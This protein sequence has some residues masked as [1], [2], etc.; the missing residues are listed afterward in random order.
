LDWRKLVEDYPRPKRFGALGNSKLGPIYQ[1]SGLSIHSCPGRTQECESVCYEAWSPKTFLGGERLL[2]KAAWYNYLAETDPNRLAKLLYHE[3]SVEGTDKI[4]IHVGGD[5]MNKKLIEVWI[6]LAL[7]FED[8]IFCAYTRSWREKK[9]LPMLTRLRDL[10]NVVLFAS[11]DSESGMPPKGWQIAPLETTPEEWL[12]DRKVID[13]PEQMG[14]KS[15]CNSCKLCYNPN[16][17]VDIRFYLHGTKGISFK[18]K[19]EKSNT[20]KLV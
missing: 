15:N 18:R 8:K 3:L 10:P 6:S 13:C 7:K 9:L 12:T 14:K 1:V 5:F 17:K 16:I 19:W 11:V 2:V 4:R 20:L